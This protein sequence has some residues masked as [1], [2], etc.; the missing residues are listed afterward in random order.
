MTKIKVN[1]YGKVIRQNNEYF[2]VD[3]YEI[4]QVA[5]K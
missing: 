4:F 2:K 1:C 5:Y 3:D